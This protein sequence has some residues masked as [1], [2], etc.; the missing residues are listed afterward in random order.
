VKVTHYDF[1]I[2]GRIPLTLCGR[3]GSF[4]FRSMRTYE[5]TCKRCLKMIR[6]RMFP[7]AEALT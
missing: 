1:S 5:V 3:R 7:L 2:P 4:T 6:V